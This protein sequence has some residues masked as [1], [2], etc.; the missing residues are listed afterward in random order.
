MK[1]L[2]VGDF[3]VTLGSGYATILLNV[4]TELA[5]RGHQV[6]VLGLYWDRSEHHFPFQVIFTDF[7]WL[8]M[9]VLRVHQA[10]NFDHVILAMDVPR[11]VQLLNE[12]EQQALNW[13]AISGLFPIESDPLISI[14]AGGLAQLYRRF[15]I[16]Q[17]GQQILADA[18]LESL[19]VPMTARV[20]EGI[21]PKLEARQALKECVL[22][23]DADLLDGKG[24][25]ALTVA[26]NQERKDLPVIARALELVEQT[27]KMRPTWLLVTRWASPHGWYLPDLFERMGIADRA[28]IFDGLSTDDLERAYYAADVFVIAS[29]AEGACLPLFEAMAHDLPCIAPNHTAISEALADDRGTLVHSNGRSIHPWG[30][31]NR[32]HVRPDDLALAI[33]G[34][35]HPGDGRMLDFIKGRTWEQAATIIEGG[36]ND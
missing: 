7:S 25:M 22:W 3:N 4:C 28:V 24:L 5:A 2:F 11:L 32:Y 6:T 20:P 21:I 31:V 33:A 12:I 30:N 19:F 10:M 26:D 29:Q 1:L 13:P 27:D 15:V 36:L 23:G 16:S 8:P 35:G 17:F 14:W 34:V 18:G 9:Q